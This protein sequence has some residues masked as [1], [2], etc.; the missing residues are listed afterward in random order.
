MLPLWGRISTDTICWS[1]SGI[2]PVFHSRIIRTTNRHCDPPVGEKTIT[3]NR[4][5]DPP[6][7]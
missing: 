1:K 7:G 4:H 5:C 3:T 2:L 6:A